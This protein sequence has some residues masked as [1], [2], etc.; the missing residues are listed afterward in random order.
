MSK[1]PK[2]GILTNPTVDIL[3][4]IENIAKLDFDFV[5]IG[6]EWPEGSPEILLKK[7]KQ[8]IDLLK[9]YNIFAIAHTAWWIDVATPY[10]LVRRAWL[11]ETKKKIKVANS[12]GIK[13]VNFHTHAREMNSFYKNY[14]KQ[15]L[16]NFVD[17]LKELVDYAK[18]YDIEIILENAVEKGEI[19]NIQLIKKITNKVPDIKIHVDIG[20]AFVC[21]GMKNIRNFFRLF[22]NR[23]VH[24][25]MHDNHGK[26][27]EH[28][29][30]GKGKIN[31]LSVIKMLKKIGYDKTITFEVF[32]SKKDAVKS[33]EYIKKL[34]NKIQV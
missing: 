3:K 33:R 5:E 18:K 28:L 27:D 21:G 12:L 32:T 29:P 34:W 4:E 8:I 10:H 15:I 22:G 7:K 25:H 9:K 1:L 26:S 13:L 6:I 11:E 16:K 2:F 24:I 19:T 17:G 31:Y 14:E 23:T 20:H 30:I